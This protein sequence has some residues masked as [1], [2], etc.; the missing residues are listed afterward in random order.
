MS[1]E[2]KNKKKFLLILL[3]ILLLLFGIT[4]ISLGFLKRDKTTQDVIIEAEVK[5]SINTL[6]NINIT[7]GSLTSSFKKIKHRMN[8]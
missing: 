3:L 8:I 7:E 4:K 5:E 6:N 2:K 1:N